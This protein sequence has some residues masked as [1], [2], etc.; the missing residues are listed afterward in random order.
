MKVSLIYL[1][2]LLFINANMLSQ[3]TCINIPDEN[4]K[5]TGY[6]REYYDNGK[7]RYEGH[8]LNDHPVGE[9]TRY[10]KTGIPQAKIIYSED[11]RET[12]AELYYLNGKIAA[13]GKYIEKLKDSTWNFYSEHDGHLALKENYLKGKR[14]GESIKYYR[15][16]KVSEKVHYTSDLLNGQWE[17]YFENGTQ[18]LDGNYLNGKRQGEFRTWNAEGKPS[19]MG[20]YEN[21]DMDGEWKYF[22]EDGE[23]DIIILYRNGVMEP[24]E[25]IERLQEEFSRRVEESIGKYSEPEFNHFR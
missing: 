19:V 20:F 17:Q 23:V 9:F 14:Q 18:R 3:D 6:W 2:F 7:V 21:G 1:M 16:N 11:G 10:Y 5:K 13:Q 24:N 8:F 15:S 25:D 22:N 12:Y 4:E